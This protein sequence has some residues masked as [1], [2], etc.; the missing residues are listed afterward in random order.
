M[1]E[2]P[3][4]DVNMHNDA[5]IAAAVDRN[6]PPELV[7][8]RASGRNSTVSYLKG[9][10][11]ADRLNEI[12]GPLGWCVSASTPKIDRFEDTRTKWDKPQG[13]GRATPK[14]VEM[15]IYAVTTQVTLTIK[16]RSEK[17]TD[18]VFVQT[19][20]GYG[21]VEPNKHAKD[22]IGMAVKGAETDGFKRCCTFL[23]KAFGMFLNSDGTQGDIEYAHRNNNEGLRK[24]QSLRSNGQRNNNQSGGS[25]RNAD[26]RDD[27]RSQG[28]RQ[29]ENSPR[30][31]SNRSERSQGRQDSGDTDRQEARNTRSQKSSE[32]SEDKQ[33]GGRST[34]SQNRNENASRS[35]SN[36]N[37]NKSSDG[38]NKPKGR[39]GRPTAHVDDNVDLTSEPVT[40]DDQI[41][42]GATIV[43]KLTE[44]SNN[45]ERVDLIRKH[46]STITNLDNA[47]YDKLKKQ[48]NKYDI[49]IESVQD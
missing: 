48:A 23:G 46:R 35:N 40:R 44:A 29:A 1:S 14:D 4:Y 49:D 25:Q 16:A 3:R 37:G 20:V 30:D 24:A 38:A 43:R 17:S 13:G 31:Q 19:G 39:T 7:S 5:A 2:S 41:S 11:D 12:F 27:N 32:Q 45:D 21:E 47:I 26:Q 8:N 34:A 15:V 42:Y 10:I 6:V 28:S 18:T 9:D 22:A 36:E 33:S